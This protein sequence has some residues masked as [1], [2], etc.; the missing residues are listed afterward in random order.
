MDWESLYCPNQYCR[1]CG[2]SFPQSRIV[3][4]GTYRG[5]K[6]GLCQ[7]VIGVYPC[8]TEQLISV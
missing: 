7:L 3:R 4:N 2:V 8:D 1:Y 6:Q 5:Q